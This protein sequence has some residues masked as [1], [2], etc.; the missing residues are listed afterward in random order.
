MKELKVGFIGAGG[1]AR[2]AHYPCVSRLEGVRIEAVAELDESRMREVVERYDIPHAFLCKSD[3]DYQRMLESVELDVVYVIM[4]PSFM[5]QP[6]IGCMNAGKHVFIE[7]PAG[8]NSDET[9]QLLEA[10]EANNV[11]CMVGYQR[12]YAAVT[13]EAMRLVKARGPATLAMGEFHKPGDYRKDN[14]D[15]LWSD[16]CHVVD[17]VRYMIGSEPVEVTAYQDAHENGRKNCFNGLIRFA[18]RAVGIVTGCRHS[19]GRYLRS[20][21]HGL[22]IGCYMRI[23][24]S[25]EIYEESKDPRVLSGAEVAGMDAGDFFAYEGTLAMHQHFVE[26]VRKGETPSSDIRDVIHTSLLV[27]RLAGDCFP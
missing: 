1:R 10:A 27:D 11:Y 21:L 15:A 19:G 7:K 2:S 12:R 6:A 5:T 8:A 22:G 18:N 25:I 24:E 17:L 14:M 16:I 3:T 26:C 13:Q 9:R 20:E 23:P 4:G